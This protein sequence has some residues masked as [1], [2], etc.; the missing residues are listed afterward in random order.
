MKSQLII[1]AL[2]ACVAAGT[3]SACSS[4]QFPLAANPAPGHPAS[5]ATK[6]APSTSVIKFNPASP[7]TVALNTTVSVTVSETG[8]SGSFKVVGCSAKLPVH[9]TPVRYGKA[10]YENYTP[11]QINSISATMYSG[12]TTMTMSN[13]AAGTYFPTIT[14]HFKIKDSLGNTATYTATSP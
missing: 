10:C 9:C 1:V 14:C 3:L 12:S 7:L 4:G 2:A 8:Y 13:Y 5:S 6:I 11:D